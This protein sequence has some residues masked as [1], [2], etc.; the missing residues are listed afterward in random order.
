MAIR[1]LGYTKTAWTFEERPVPSSKLNTWD[2]RIELALELVYFLLS[3]AWGGG[4]GV[5]RNATTDDLK[6]VASSTPDLAVHVKPGYAFVSKLPYKLGA[7]A[8]T[9]AI[10]PPIT[11][12]RIDLV[13]ARLETWDVSVVTGTEH[14]SPAAPPAQ[15]DCIPLAKLYLRPGMA[16]IKNADDATNG[17]I[18]DAR[19][20]V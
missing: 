5:I 2:N 20:F 19:M 11:N 7:E 3:H 18:S 15:T 14:A 4:D 10:T 8:T 1:G 9:A 17:Y 13:Q 6:V 12:P 16:S